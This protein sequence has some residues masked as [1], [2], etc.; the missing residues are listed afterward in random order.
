MKRYATH[1]RCI[2][3]D[4]IPLLR[5]WMQDGQTDAEI[6]ERLGMG[7]FTFRTWLVKYRDEFNLPYRHVWN[8]YNLQTVATIAEM[9]LRKMSW[10]EIAVAGN[11]GHPAVLRKKMSDKARLRGMS[12][13]E[14]L[15]KT[16]K[17]YQKYSKP[18][19]D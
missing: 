10:R 13:R 12:L 15:L 6:A 7:I 11:F 2:Q 14:Y 17:M 3:Q 4:Q 19:F 8:R 9:R 16:I 18:N 1:S 5:Q